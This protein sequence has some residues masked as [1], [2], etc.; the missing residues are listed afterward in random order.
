RERAASV[1]DRARGAQHH[2]SDVPTPP[3]QPQSAAEQ[4]HLFARLRRIVMGDG[5]GA[6]RRS[7]GADRFVNQNAERLAAEP[8]DQ[9]DRRSSRTA[10]AIVSRRSNSPPRS[11][12]S[13]AAM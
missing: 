7:A 2:Q 4:P 13:P 6:F 11:L 3:R 5:A 8:L 12:I 10:P 1:H 9:S